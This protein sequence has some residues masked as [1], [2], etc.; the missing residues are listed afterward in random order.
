MSNNNSPSK[1]RRRAC[2]QCAKDNVYRLH[3]IEYS[4]S[5]NPYEYNS[6]DYNRFKRFY[7]R[8]RESYH[9]MEAWCK[10]LEEVYGLIGTKKYP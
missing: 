7:N 6:L 9:R 5:V 1:Q 8:T 4:D 10:D 3:G 2:E